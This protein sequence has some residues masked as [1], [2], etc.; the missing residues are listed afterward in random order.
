MS[1]KVRCAALLVTALFAGGAHA[2][3]YAQGYG[4][5]PTEAID[6]ALKAAEKIVISRGRGCVGPGKDGGVEA[7]RYVKK[8]RDLY[9]FEA[10]YS[11][12]DG[13]CGKRKTV[14]DYRKELG[15]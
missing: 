6:N 14:A 3:G 11:H 4:T 10:F 12:H 2:G 9:V 13:S 15:F 7:V 5:T 8:D 1:R